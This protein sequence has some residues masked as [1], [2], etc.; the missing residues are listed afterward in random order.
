ML[1]HPRLPK[2]FS[3]HEVTQVEKHRWKWHNKA[4][5]P[6]RGRCI[7]VFSYQFTRSKLEY[8]LEETYEL[9]NL[10]FFQVLTMI[11]LTSAVRNSLPRVTYTKYSD[12]ILILCLIYVFGALVE[13]AIINFHDSLEARKRENLNN[14]LRS[15]DVERGVCGICLWF[16]FWLIV[17]DLVIEP[18]TL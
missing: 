9:N 11:T 10:S 6:V 3:A 18:L 14:K 8:I 1:V 4:T 17:V 7:D 15:I 13:F 5:V 2:Y 12:W 16:N